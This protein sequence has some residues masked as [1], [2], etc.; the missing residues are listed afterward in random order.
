MLLQRLIASILSIFVLCGFAFA[1]DDSAESEGPSISAAGDEA[2]HFEITGEAARDVKEKIRAALVS[3]D[4]RIWSR[5]GLTHPD[6]I[7][8]RICADTEEF[9]SELSKFEVHVEPESILGLS[10]PARDI[11]FINLGMIRDNLILNL[12]RVLCHELVHIYAEGKNLPL[13]YEEGLCQWTSGYYLIGGSVDVPTAAANGTLVPLFEYADNYPQNPDSKALFYSQSESIV[14]YVADRFSGR[15]IHAEILAG[16]DGNSDF[17]A[18][19]LRATSKT[20]A[21]IEKEW[22]EMITPG[23]SSAVALLFLNPEVAISLAFV[24]L[25]VILFVKIWLRNRRIW[26]EYQQEEDPDERDV[27]VPTEFASDEDDPD[28]IDPED[29]GRFPTSR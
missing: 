16:I 1:E 3:Y 15:S 2:P 27:F 7:E 22:R 25:A 5:L 29:L 21:S 12:D 19:F 6:E 24:L 10:L 14:S 23:G 11:C 13:W 18:A 9:L 17:A 26:R 8:V 4:A 28:E 20:P